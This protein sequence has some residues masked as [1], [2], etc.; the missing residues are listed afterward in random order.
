MELKDR[1]DSGFI[2]R[3]IQFIIKFIKRFN[4]ER[5]MKEASNLTFVTVLGFV[6]FMLFIVFIVPPIQS[7]NVRNL[8]QHHLITNLL[9]ESVD[10]IN[11][12]LNNLLTKKIPMNI[13]NVIMVLFTSYSMFYS[14]TTAFDKILGFRTI[15]KTKIV[16]VLLKFFGTIMFGFLITVL[17]FSI[18]SVSLVNIVFN[19]TILKKLVVTLLPMFIW[20]LLTFFIYYLVPSKRLNIKDISKI[21]IIVAVLW[22][23]LKNGFDWYIS[24]LTRMH[25]FYGVI[26]S[27]PIF[28]FWI[29]AN[30]IITL[31]GVIFLSDKTKHK[32]KKRVTVQNIMKIVVEEQKEIYVEEDLSLT[33]MKNDE[34]LKCIKEKLKT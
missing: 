33:T 25:V 8:I 12:Q 18:S 22:F 4:Q 7:F 31:C 5:I 11:S 15:K 29:Y 17:L 20:F 1:K 19:Q 30:W 10:I 13:F 32:E 27:F 23:I 21:S 6:P 2:R 24:N 14:I 26:A 3:T 9:P 34:L 16:D 28:L